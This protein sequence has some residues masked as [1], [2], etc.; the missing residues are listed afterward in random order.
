[1]MQPLVNL[2]CIL[3]MCAFLLHPTNGFDK[4]IILHTTLP[5]DNHYKISSSCKLSDTLIYSAYETSYIV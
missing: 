1:M 2:F 3:T 4:N 5:I